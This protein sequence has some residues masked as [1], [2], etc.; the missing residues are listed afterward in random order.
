LL[1]IISAGR[2]SSERIILIGV[3]ARPRSP[4]A[5]IAA[6]RAL[7]SSGEAALLALPCLLPLA[8][9][10]S[11]PGPALLEEAAQ[12]LEGGFST[13]DRRESDGIPYLSL[14]PESRLRGAASVLSSLSCPA[15]FP[16][17]PG[18]ALASQAADAPFPRVPLRS[19]RLEAYELESSASGWKAGFSWTLCAS[20]PVRSPRKRPLRD[21]KSGS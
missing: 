1:I 11:L 10:A 17:L 4:D 13:G 15:P 2:D 16:I 19:L 21:G 8:F 7:P 9:S 3:N 5:L 20:V 6:R 14:E 18:P 12:A